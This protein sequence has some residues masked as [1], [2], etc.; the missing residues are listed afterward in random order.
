MSSAPSNG[1]GNGEDASALLLHSPPPASS[2][3]TSPTNPSRDSTA[4][5][6]YKAADSEPGHDDNG[7]GG[8]GSRGGGGG[9]DSGD[10]S[11]DRDS[12]RSDNGPTSREGGSSAT[13][14]S[15]GPRVSHRQSARK[16]YVGNLPAAATEKDVMD[17]FAQSPVPCALPAQ[18]DMKAGYAFVVSGGD[19]T[20]RLATA[21]RGSSG[22]D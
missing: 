1:E 2:G 14:S 12:R 21:G 19:D 20:R 4:A 8:G 7:G 18:I 15:L 16:I 3:I 17:L 11:R 13:L 5:D 9:G 22:G 10:G 6:S